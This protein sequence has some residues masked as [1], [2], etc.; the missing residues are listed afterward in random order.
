MGVNKELKLILSNFREADRVL[1]RLKTSV[2]DD[3]V[4]YAEL[5]DLQ[6]KMESAWM[7]YDDKVKFKMFK[8]KESAVR[9]LVNSFNDLAYKYNN[10]SNRVLNEIEE[11]LKE[12]LESGDAEA[13]SRLNRVADKLKQTADDYMYQAE[14]RVKEIGKYFRDTTQKQRNARAFAEIAP[15]LAVGAVAV[16][17]ATTLAVSGV[18][19]NEFRNDIAE[20]RREND[21]Y[22]QQLAEKDTYINSLLQNGGSGVSQETYDQ[23]LNDYNALKG[24]YDAVMVEYNKYL[25]L[26]PEGKEPSEYIQ[27]LVA[28]IG[29]YQAKLSAMETQIALLKSANLVLKNQISD[30]Q[31]E[32]ST[33]RDA[34]TALEN[35]NKDLEKQVE[36][37]L[38]GNN[39]ELVASLRKI[40]A[41][42]EKT[43]SDNEKAI[44][45]KDKTIAELTKKNTEYDKTIADMEASH[46]TEVEG[47]KTTIGNLESALKVEQDKNAGLTAENESLKT[48]NGN[49]KT[50]NDELKI[51][52]EEYKELVSNINTVYASLVGGSE[53]DPK[54]QLQG[55]VDVLDYYVDL[56]DQGGLTAEQEDQ[57]IANLIAAFVSC[58]ADY[59]EISH[60]NLSQI[61]DWLR[62]KVNAFGTPSEGPNGNVHE[63]GTSSS[64]PSG[65]NNSGSGESEK[66][67]GDGTGNIS[68][69][70]PVRGDR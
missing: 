60:M 38:A 59:S 13:E 48:E 54:A 63:N 23:L 39:D 12:K 24:K 29:D 5:A 4:V 44:A 20:V 67:E 61:A 45:E 36:D 69:D 2:I 8:A 68:G 21:D 58:G 11:N 50:E 15:K 51:T 19:Y 52:E 17:L 35:A 32:I 16:G 30:L 64:T 42:N 22:K 55:I 7:R 49:L 27:G 18:Q 6:Q 10:A 37:A 28:T 47:Y 57:V 33:L 9:E 46:A 1:E 3:V 14:I 62:L 26:I 41:D 43:I 70:F 31:N 66:E 53:T 65:G 40:I 56:V 34:N 25:S